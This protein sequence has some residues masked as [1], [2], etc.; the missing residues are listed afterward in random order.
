[1]TAP[2]AHYKLRHYLAASSRRIWRFVVVRFTRD[3]YFSHPFP[4]F[5]AQFSFL[6]RRRIRN[7]PAFVGFFGAEFFDHEYNAHLH[8]WVRM[9]NLLELLN[10]KAWIWEWK[11]WKRDSESGMKRYIF[12]IEICEEKTLNDWKVI[13]FTNF[14]MIYNC[15]VIF[16]DSF[17]GNRCGKIF[18]LHFLFCILYSGRLIRTVK[19]IWH[20]IKLKVHLHDY[21]FCILFSKHLMYV[22]WIF[23]HI[24][25]E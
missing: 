20:H 2:V 21:F 4:I 1:M 18:I 25:K 5:Q 23:I 19:N 17:F 8:R 24:Y 3:F 12:K 6:W 22:C 10:L 13:W 7:D 14:R 15:Y 9:E 11:I 16:C